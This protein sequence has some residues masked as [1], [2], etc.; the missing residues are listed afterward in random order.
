MDFLCFLTF[1]KTGN[2]SV[3]G[4][5]VNEFEFNCKLHEAQY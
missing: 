5:I 3:N 1:S 4:R 2:H